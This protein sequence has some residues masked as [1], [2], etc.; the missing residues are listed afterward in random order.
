M[1]G[2]PKEV[3]LL[4][5]QFA[6]PWKPLFNTVLAELLE[7]SI[8]DAGIY[9]GTLPCPRCVYFSLEACGHMHVQVANVSY[10]LYMKR[11]KKE[12]H[13]KGQKLLDCQIYNVL[14]PKKVFDILCP[15]RK[16]IPDREDMFDIDM[17]LVRDT[18]LSIIRK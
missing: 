3:E 9:P 7:D 1:F 12:L 5:W 15:R 10:I 18:V 16:H 2:L 6:D 13:S 14:Y 4:I 8:G 17:L 11:S